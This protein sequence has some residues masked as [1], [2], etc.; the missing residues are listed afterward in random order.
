MDILIGRPEGKR[1]DVR[2]IGREYVDWMHMAQY[3]DQ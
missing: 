2:E 3:R 1:L